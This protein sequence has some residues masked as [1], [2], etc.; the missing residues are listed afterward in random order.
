MTLPTNT[1]TVFD[2]VGNRE[3][4]SDMIYNIA[5]SD[6]PIIQAIGKTKASGVYHEWQTDS[7]AS[8]DTA[9]YVIEG[10]DATT[11][12]ATA[13]VRLGNRC[14][15]MD[16]VARVTGTL[17]AINRA[18]RSDEM[19]YQVV[20]KTK[21]LK[22]DMEAWVASNNIKATGTTSTARKMAGMLAWISTNTNCDSG[23]SDPSP[24]DG[25]DAR[26][27]GTQRVFTE[28]QLKDALAQCWAEGGNPS[29][30]YVGAFNKQKF[31]GFTGGATR[32]DDAAD[33]R[34]T[35]AVDVYISDFGTLRV[36]P[37]RFSR[38]RD[39]LVIDP[40]YWALAYLRPLSTTVLAKTGDSER[41]QL[42]VEFTLEAR[43]EK[44]SGGV[45]DLTT[46]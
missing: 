24:I 26:N 45:F 6:T 19:D 5:P 35:A 46:S 43:N 44:A 41:K 37:S 29:N 22:R 18:G 33:K 1:F 23:G 8:V 4:L 15:I 16:K 2:S 14:Q 36:I 32:M 40:E 39:A 34:I 10:D 27:D 30:I 25:S 12:A 13:T 42:L 31:S 28:A 3:D 17:Q 9:N 38:T 20:K 21:E 11:D 7:L